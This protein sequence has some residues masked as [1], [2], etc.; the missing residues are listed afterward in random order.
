MTRERLNMLGRVCVGNARSYPE[1]I[2]QVADPTIVPRVERM[3]GSGIVL[4]TD[5]IHGTD[6]LSA[7]CRIVL[8][9]QATPMPT[10]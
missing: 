6:E 3:I 8:T 1:L 10:I 4:L 2:A 7:H 5:S 9:F